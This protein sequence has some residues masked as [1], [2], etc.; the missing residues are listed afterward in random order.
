MKRTYLEEDTRLIQKY[1]PGARSISLRTPFDLTD[2]PEP[3]LRRVPDT[4]RGITSQYR[5]QSG[6]TLWTH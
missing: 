3:R 1:F 5:G 4:L 2:Q 6:D